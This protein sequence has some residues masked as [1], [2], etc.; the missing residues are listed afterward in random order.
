MFS[1]D[2]EVAFDFCVP[3]SL[4]ELVLLGETS[5]FFLVLS[6]FFSVGTA[7]FST[8]FSDVCSDLATV[9]GGEV[10]VLGFA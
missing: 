10:S 4:E 7:F 8:F 5:S 1:S 6:S 3:F 9:L 2:L